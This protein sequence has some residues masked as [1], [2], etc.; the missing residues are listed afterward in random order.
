MAYKMTYITGLLFKRTSWFQRKKELFSG[1]VLCNNQTLLQKDSV[2]F[3]A[4]KGMPETY[5]NY[6]NESFEIPWVQY[7]R[8]LSSIQPW[9]QK[10]VVG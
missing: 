1:Q 9:E 6:G 4:M 5:G 2:S 8:T 7:R 3:K 10:K